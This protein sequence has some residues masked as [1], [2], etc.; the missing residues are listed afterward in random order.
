MQ[1]S[2]T[3]HVTRSDEATTDVGGVRMPAADI[4]HIFAYHNPSDTDLEDRV[5]DEV[6]DNL[7][8]GDDDG[9]CMKSSSHTGDFGIKGDVDELMERWHG[10]V[11]NGVSSADPETPQ[12]S[13][14]CTC[15]ELVL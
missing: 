15:R 9:L 10:K 1:R 8:V 3:H 11:R 7:Q 5:N 12:S 2:L 14:Q 4:G 6:L 13:I